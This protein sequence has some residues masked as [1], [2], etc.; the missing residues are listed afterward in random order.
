[1]WHLL[2]EVAETAIACQPKKYRSRNIE[3]ELSFRL[4]LS[5]ELLH[6]LIFFILE[7]SFRPKCQ[8]LQSS[9]DPASHSAGGQDSENQTPKK[10]L[11]IQR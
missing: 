6:F 8:S 11:I 5:Y 4:H 2:K 7:F 3:V 10:Y 1:M 9:N